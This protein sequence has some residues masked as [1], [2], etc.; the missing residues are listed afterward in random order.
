MRQNYHLWIAKRERGRGREREDEALWR[1]G[2]AP[3]TMI[4][5]L[6][7]E[8]L[9]S[10]PGLSTRLDL[11]AR[12]TVALGYADSLAAGREGRSRAQGSRLV[13]VALFRV[14]CC[15]WFRNMGRSGLLL[16]TC[17]VFTV[18]QLTTLYRVPVRSTVRSS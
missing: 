10:P 15:S 1:E 4:R 14:K 12:T 8:L 9:T 7:Q 11:F 18:I 2:G 3:A 16:R 6:D 17:S 5:Y 13:R